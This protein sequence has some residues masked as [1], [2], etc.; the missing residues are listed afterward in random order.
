[1]KFFKNSIMKTI[2]A[3]ML[4]IAMAVGMTASL[5]GNANAATTVTITYGA[6][7]GYSTTNG[8]QSVKVTITSGASTTMLSTFARPGFTLSGWQI[9]GKTTK[10]N[11][12]QSVKFTAN[13]ELV[14]VWSPNTIKITYALC[15]GTWKNGNTT[16]TYTYGKKYSLNPPACV[17]TGYT[18]KGWNT[19]SDGSGTL[20]QAGQTNTMFSKDTT[21][22]AIWTPNTCKVTYYANGGTWKNGPTSQSFTVGKGFTLAPPDMVRDGYVLLGYSTDPKAKTATYYKG[23]TY[24]SDTNLALYA[25]WQKYWVVTLQY[26]QKKETKIVYDGSDFTFPAEEKLS[27]GVY[28]DYWTVQHDPN[29]S[30]FL[31]AYKTGSKQKVTKDITYVP[32]GKFV[33]VN[34]VT[35]PSLFA[36]KPLNVWVVNEAYKKEFLKAHPEDKIMIIKNSSG[37]NYQIVDSY[38]YYWDF[39]IIQLV[40]GALVE[41]NKTYNGTDKWNRTAISCADEWMEHN[42]FYDMFS[43]AEFLASDIGI[44]FLK[45]Y[46]G[47]N[48]DR[49]RNVDL[50]ANDSGPGEIVKEAKKVWNK[51]L[52]LFK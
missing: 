50:G 22:Y 11:V 8:Q 7:G 49:T 43:N 32:M 44:D 38:K 27:D 15:G 39:A 21:L 34:I 48:A 14:A 17:R 23:K 10:Y 30:C 12:G 24:K 9:K 40:C 31:P 26:R 41:Y 6:N 5:G 20:Y 2:T 52:S 33:W 13:T 46:C 4:I 36:G 29:E 19:K 18:L 37:T 47:N 35:I 3:A 51:F 28:T 16:Q 42:V 1:M 25:V 45:N